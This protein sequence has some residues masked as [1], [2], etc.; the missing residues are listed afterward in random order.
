MKDYVLF[1]VISML[2]CHLK[3]VYTDPAQ[4]GW[5]NELHELVVAHVTQKAL[6]TALPFTREKNR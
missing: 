6:Q 2:Y 1:S 3:K 5:S 4:S